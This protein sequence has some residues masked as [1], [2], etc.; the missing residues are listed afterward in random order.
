[1]SSVENYKQYAADCVR[2][3]EG[4]ETAEEKNVLLNVALAWLRLA[5]QKQA[6]GTDAQ[7]VETESKPRKKR[8]SVAKDVAAPP[9]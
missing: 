8:T 9:P 6:V 1:M 7:S 3:A 5:Q 2:Q 4:A